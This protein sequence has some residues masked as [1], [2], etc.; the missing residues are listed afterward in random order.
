[1]HCSQIATKYKSQEFDPQLVVNYIKEYPLVNA[2][3]IDKAEIKR[4]QDELKV[5]VQENAKPVQLNQSEM[6]AVIKSRV[7][8][9]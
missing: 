6:K 3:A 1:M 4:L 7:I 5:H 2:K 8:K 9:S